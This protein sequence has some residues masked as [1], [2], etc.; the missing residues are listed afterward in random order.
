MWRLGRYDFDDGTALVTDQ[1]PFDARSTTYL[2]SN[3]SAYQR[4][5]GRF[6]AG[7]SVRPPNV[8][9][10]L[11][12]Q[13]VVPA[14]ELSLAYRGQTTQ[15]GVEGHLD[16]TT[17][18]TAFANVS[19][20]YNRS[21]IQRFEY[22]LVLAETGRIKL[23]YVELTVS[24]GNSTGTFDISSRY[25]RVG[26]TTVERP[27]WFGEAVAAAPT[28]T[29]EGP[30]VRTFELSDDRGRFEQTVTAPRGTYWR[31]AGPEHTGSHEFSYDLLYDASVGP[32]VRLDWPDAAT[33]VEASYHYEESQ[34]PRGNESALTV[35]VYDREDQRFV[36]V[37]D[38][39]GMHAEVDAD[40][41][42]VT[43]VVM[44][45]D[46]LERYRGNAF[47]AIDFEYFL[48]NWPPD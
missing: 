39:E 35:V 38:V 45:E 40:A 7:R 4:T 44:G 32:I 42:V 27:D 46:A 48:D 17:N 10:V 18:P 20:K 11:R 23:E 22:G 2:A 43:L 1:S 37:Q 9:T 3:G 13:F 8:S 36:P 47:I 34:V 30:E 19:E 12:P 24:D 29:P 31:D 33:E 14:D 41:D 21:T 25:T 15:C 5:G 6:H 28:P 26:E 16:S